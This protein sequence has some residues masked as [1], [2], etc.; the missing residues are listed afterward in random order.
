MQLAPTRARAQFER[1]ADV[2]TSFDI[3]RNGGDRRERFA[4]AALE[5]DTER[6]CF[7]T[8]PFFHVK[9]RKSQPPHI[10]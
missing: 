2:Q 8:D 4:A 3:E 1:G 10:W 6:T 5:G 9:A 7:E